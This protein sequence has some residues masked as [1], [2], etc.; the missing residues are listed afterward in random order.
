MSTK[1]YAA[2]DLFCGIGGLTHGFI[3]E[4]IPVIAGFDIDESCR[5]AYMSNN[6]ALFFCKPIEKT[7]VN[8]IKKLYPKNSIKIL[9]GCAPCQPFS[10]YNRGKKQEKMNLLN[11][12]GR[13]IVGVKPEIVTMENVP[14]LTKYEIFNQFVENLKNHGYYVNYKVVYCPDYNIPQKRRRLVLLAS[15]LGEINLI[16]KN[17]SPCNRNVRT[18]IGHLEPIEAGETSE[19]DPLHRT[20]N[21]STLNKIRIKNTP[22]GGSWLDWDDDLILECHKKTTGKTYKS[23]YGRMKWDDFAPTITTEFHGYGSGR[24]G[25]PDQDRAISYR[26]AALLQTFPK[27]YKILKPNSLFIGETIAKQIGNAVP[28]ELGRV[29]ARSIKRHLDAT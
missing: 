7:S 29:I 1:A 12:F 19:S 18:E 16:E 26:E 3:K 14:R 13:I 20:R 22:A 4:N 8:N 17:K 15:R 9:M 5:Y 6:N 25:H 2:I 11:E 21:L 10:S 28:F 24:F 23:I 27:Y